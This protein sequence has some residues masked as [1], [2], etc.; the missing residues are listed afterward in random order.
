MLY[1]RD[2]SRTT[3]LHGIGCCCHHAHIRARVPP[4]P[5]Q[6]SRSRQALPEAHAHV[7]CQA[8]HLSGGKG[9]A[10]GNHSQRSTQDRRRKTFV[11]RRE[12]TCISWTRTQ[13][14]FPLMLSCPLMSCRSLWTTKT[15]YIP[16]TN[17]YA[18]IRALRGSL[19]KVTLRQQIVSTHLDRLEQERLAVDEPTFAFRTVLVHH[20]MLGSARLLCRRTR[21]T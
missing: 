1:K 17:Q 3:S 15:A 14:S 9:T 8:F 7:D 4:G 16:Q 2:R 11:C 21:R 18:C 5:W 6:T 20:S 10:R 12:F 13:V 19:P